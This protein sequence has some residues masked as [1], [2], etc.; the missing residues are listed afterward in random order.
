[1]KLKIR[2]VP[3]NYIILFSLYL[4]DRTAEESLSVSSLHDLVSVGTKVYPVSISSLISALGSTLSQCLIPIDDDDT[5]LEAYSCISEHLDYKIDL[6]DVSDILLNYLPK[7][8][9]LTRVRIYTD[10]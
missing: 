3:T 5:V 1:M 6:D 10:T 7:S 9:T 2:S 4:S 8:S